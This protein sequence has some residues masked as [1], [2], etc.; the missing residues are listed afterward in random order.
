MIYLYH[1]IENSKRPYRYNDSDI[2]L[3][4]MMSSYLINFIKT[5]NPNGA[6]LPTWTMWTEENN[7]IFEFG[8]NKG[9]IDD[10]FSF[11]YEFMKN[12]DEA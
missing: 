3:S 8:E 7:K 5:G 11:L 2:E 10:P 4:N 12:Y 1:N 6:D 9:M